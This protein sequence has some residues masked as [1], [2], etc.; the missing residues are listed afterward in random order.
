MRRGAAHCDFGNVQPAVRFEL[1]I[2][3]S[4]STEGKAEKIVEEI[5]EELNA[6]LVK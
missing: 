6:V 3:G 4:L 5:H 2:D 1:T